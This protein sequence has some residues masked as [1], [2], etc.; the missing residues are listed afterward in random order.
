MPCLHISYAP[1]TYL[2]PFSSPLL[3]YQ[4]VLGALSGAGK[5]I[6]KS[7]SLAVVQVSVYALIKLL[8]GYVIYQNVPCACR[9]SNSVYTL[10][11]VTEGI[12]TIALL[13]SGQLDDAI[14]V[15]ALQQALLW[16]TFLPIAYPMLMKVYDGVVVT[17]RVV[18]CYREKFSPQTALVTLSVMLLAVPKF[19]R[20]GLGKAQR[21]SGAIT[22]VFSQ[23]GR[24][25]K[26]ATADAQ[27]QHTSNKQPRA[28][29]K[30]CRDAERAVAQAEA[31]SARAYQHS[32]SHA[33]ARSRVVSPVP[34]RVL[35]HSLLQVES[36]VV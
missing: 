5:Y 32:R 10:E 34:P 31:V 18:N 21:V 12:V 36:P 6:D 26:A 9:L 20:K 4:I 29:A 3:A 27:E 2:V 35:P 33:G 19:V 23:V 11:Y 22:G 7:S 30:A 14:N 16:L 1:L 13:I 17:N 24:G 8:W 25:V 28:I 15:V